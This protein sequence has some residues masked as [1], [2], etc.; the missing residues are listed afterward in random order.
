M[1]R[2]GMKMP[3]DV[4]LDLAII[5]KHHGLSRSASIYMLIRDEAR[6]I[7]ISKGEDYDSPFEINDQ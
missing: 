4:A 7:I 1:K 3:D 6:K 2:F 5:A